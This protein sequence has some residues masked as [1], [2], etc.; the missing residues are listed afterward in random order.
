MS[1]D[2]YI[3]GFAECVMMNERD[4]DG[5]MI[6]FALRQMTVGF[7]WEGEYNRIRFDAR[8]WTWNE[9]KILCV[10]TSPTKFLFLLVTKY[11]GSQS[12]MRNKRCQKAQPTQ[13]ATASLDLI[14]KGI[15]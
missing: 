3:A 9:L 8:G 12:F 13:V 4:D 14:H 2:R 5:P 1:A 10:T 15:I 6:L 7:R 11:Q